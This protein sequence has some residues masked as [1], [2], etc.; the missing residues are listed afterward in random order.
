M[1]II[2]K[3]KINKIVLIKQNISNILESNSDNALII[4]RGKDIVEIYINFICV[5][6][7]QNNN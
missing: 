1:V 4:E 5:F 2:Q 3:Q 7:Q 6:I